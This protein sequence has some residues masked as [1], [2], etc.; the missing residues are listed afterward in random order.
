MRIYE[1]FPDATNKPV[2]NYAEGFCP[3]M[4][5]K[6]TRF[7]TRR[8]SWQ[9]IYFKDLHNRVGEP[10]PS[11]HSLNPNRLRL[12]LEKSELEELPDELKNTERLN[13][14]FKLDILEMIERFDRPSRPIK[15]FISDR[16]DKLD[17]LERLDTISKLKKLDRSDLLELLEVLYGSDRPDILGRFRVIDWSDVSDLSDLSDVSSVPEVSN[18]L[19]TI[20]G[21]GDR[22]KDFSSGG[23]DWEWDVIFNS[24]AES[25]LINLPV[26]KI[27]SRS[28]VPKYY[29]DFYNHLDYN[30]YTSG[31]T[32]NHV[33]YGK[34]EWISFMDVD[35][36]FL[37]NTYIFLGQTPLLIDLV[38]GFFIAFIY[39]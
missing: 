15:P 1:Y 30:S 3:T 22:L 36:N 38:L 16:L 8:L 2:I 13:R 11:S 39:L 17:K 26:N 23:G 27:S 12:V 32:F 14:F 18:L 20:P 28:Y 7:I 21:K 29:K 24:S 19:E 5:L 9:H 25:I 4:C 34:Y 10:L 35:W 31:Y 37:I 6:K 33:G